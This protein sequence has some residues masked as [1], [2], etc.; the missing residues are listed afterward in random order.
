MAVVIHRIDGEHHHIEN[1]HIQHAVCQLRRVGGQSDVPHNALRLQVKQI[2]QNTVSLIILQITDLIQTVHEAKVNII[3][4]QLLQL[5]C[6]GFFDAVQRR[7]PAVFAGGIVRAE[8][9]LYIRVLPPSGKGFADAG[10]NSGVTA[11]KIDIVDTAVQ[12]ER[13]RLH[14]VLNGVFSDNRGS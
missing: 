9:Q 1:S 6:D 4:F 10:E 8:M 13:H 14:D 2:V 12:R 7:V 5:P 11:C 3:C